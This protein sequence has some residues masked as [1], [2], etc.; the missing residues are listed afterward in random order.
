MFTGLRH[1]PKEPDGNADGTL[2]AFDPGN[3]HSYKKWTNVME[4]FVAGIMTSEQPVY[5]MYQKR[6]TE[7]KCRMTR[8]NYKLHPRTNFKISNQKYLPK[9]N[10]YKFTFISDFGEQFS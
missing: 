2:I 6:M 5:D 8:E 9:R 1:G 4:D 7:M 3:S 10:N